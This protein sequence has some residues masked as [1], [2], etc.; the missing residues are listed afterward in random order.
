M[1]SIK[2]AREFAHA[3]GYGIVKGRKTTHPWDVVFPDGGK[4]EA[5]S[6]T[7]AVEIIKNTWRREHKSACQRGIVDSYIKSILDKRK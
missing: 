3:L 4:A 5:R 7:V 6:I 1:A 2:K